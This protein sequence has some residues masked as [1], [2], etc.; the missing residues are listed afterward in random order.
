MQFCKGFVSPEKQKGL[1]HNGFHLK[2]LGVSS[3]KD[4]H[5]PVLFHRG[6]YSSILFAANYFFPIIFKFF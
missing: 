1:R 4:N 6:P 3:F 5:F 2:G